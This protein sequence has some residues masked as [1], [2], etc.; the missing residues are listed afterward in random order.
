MKRRGWPH[1]KTAKMDISTLLVEQTAP[2]VAADASASFTKVS[3]RT[4]P[5]PKSCDWNGC[6]H[7]ANEPSTPAMVQRL[8]FDTHEQQRSQPPKRPSMETPPY[9]GRSYARPHN[10][11][12][13]TPLNG[14]S[15]ENHIPTMDPRFHHH[16]LRTPLPITFGIEN[17]ITATSVLPINRSTKG[18]RPPPSAHS[19][20][21]RGKKKK[22][23]KAS[24]T[25][26]WSPTEDA[27]IIEMRHNRMKWEDIAKC[28]PG[29]S[30]LSCRLRFQNYL[31]RRMEWNDE[32]KDKLAR[33]YER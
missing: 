18:K 10:H 7:C 5:T 30:A 3:H 28:L 21:P 32:K 24:R 13:S 1:S 9:N 11:S 6:A 25:S 27:A 23:T 15:S 4:L 22:S 29:R 33:L 14:Y 17:G 16:Q 20:E 26:K 19:P 12:N 31:E 8:P 2:V